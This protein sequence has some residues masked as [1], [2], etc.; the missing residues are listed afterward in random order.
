MLKLAL[1]AFAVAVPTAAAAQ[2]APAAPVAPAAEPAPPAPPAPAAS[3]AP[4]TPEAMASDPRMIAA[5]RHANAVADRKCGAGIG[6]VVDIS[7]RAEA[8]RCRRRIIA[9]AKLDAQGEIEGH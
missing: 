8:Q 5:I 1:I 6:G 2:V 9:T 3:T 4:L 7:L